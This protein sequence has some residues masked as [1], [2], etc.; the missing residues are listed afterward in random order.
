[1]QLN[2][3]PSISPLASPAAALLL[4]ISIEVYVRY[5]AH[6]LWKLWGFALAF[7]AVLL[8]SWPKRQSSMTPGALILSALVLLS[9]IS[10]LGIRFPGIIKAPPDETASATFNLLLRFSLVLSACLLSARSL[11][12]GIEKVV[13]AIEVKRQRKAPQVG[14]TARGT[15]SRPGSD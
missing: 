6:P 14:L 13:A 8:L 1:M 10:T 15:R 4:T 9:Y 7:L 3:T 5:S 11:L 12:W 2:K